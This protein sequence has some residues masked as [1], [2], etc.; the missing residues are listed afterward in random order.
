[1]TRENGAQWFGNPF[2]SDLELRCKDGRIF[3]IHKPF[4]TDSSGFL[5]NVLDDT[6]GTD[7]HIDLD[8]KFCSNRLEPIIRWMYTGETD[9]IKPSRS[10][11]MMRE[12]KF[13]LMDKDFLEQLR[14]TFLD[15]WR[16]TRQIDLLMSLPEQATDFSI[17]EFLQLLDE[18]DISCDTHG[19]LISDWVGR[20]KMRGEDL[21]ELRK[22]MSEIITR[23]TQTLLEEICDKSP[24]VFDDLFP[25][26]AML[27]RTR[28][29][30]KEEEGRFRIRCSRCL[31]VFETK[32]QADADPC[33]E[34]V[35]HHLKETY[36]SRSGVRCCSQCG[37]SHDIP[38]PWCHKRIKV[39]HSLKIEH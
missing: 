8:E 22:H 5:K 2:A 15:S 34:R 7:G 9:L 38:P 30:E 27:E 13:L 16:E 6:H 12:A 4:V 32:R 25:G 37:K 19:R 28:K 10:I 36:V 33:Y 14:Q 1:M 29:L 23:C 17:Q 35:S 24:E 21:I 31:K 18:C 39:E 26:S 20:N 3:F 11:G